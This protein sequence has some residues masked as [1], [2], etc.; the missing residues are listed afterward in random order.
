MQPIKTPM[1]G[2]RLFNLITVAHERYRSAFY[3][4]LR[5]T[6]VADNMNQATKV[7][8]GAKRFRVVTLSGELIETSGTMSG[9]GRSKMTGK[10]GQ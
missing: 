8:Y 9:G 7:A 6:L 10:M 1:G 5:D 3:H 2:L 4:Y